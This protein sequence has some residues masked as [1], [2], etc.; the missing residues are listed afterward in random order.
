MYKHEDAYKVV[1]GNNSVQVFHKS[2]LIKKEYGTE[3]QSQLKQKNVQ[4]WKDS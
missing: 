3:S 4:S 1:G 2:D